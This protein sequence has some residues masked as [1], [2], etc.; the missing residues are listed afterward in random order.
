VD[1]ASGGTNLPPRG[2]FIDIDGVRLHY[3]DK[4]SGP[5][6]LLIHGLAGQVL[7]FTHSLLSRLTHD[8]RVVI[9][10]RPGSGYSLRP[11]ATLAP[12]AA[13]ARIISRFCQALGLER[14]V[15]VGHSLGGVIA[16]ALALDHPEQVGALA[17]I[18]RSRTSRR[19]CRRPLMVSLSARRCCAA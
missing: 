9:L 12:L 14:P 6:L 10:D 18:A 8:F 11:D 3:I 13:Q 7:N 15:I 19:A 1:R 16:L 4:G 17:L 2:K 5:T